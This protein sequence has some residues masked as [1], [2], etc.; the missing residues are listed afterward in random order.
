ML[1]RIV[2]IHGPQVASR[3]RKA[4]SHSISMVSNILRLALGNTARTDR[5]S[6][7]SERKQVIASHRV[8]GQTAIHHGGSAGSNVSHTLLDRTSNWL[9]SCAMKVI[10]TWQPVCFSRRKVEKARTL[11]VRCFNP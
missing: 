7:I 9:R 5:L 6:G 8:K 10:P 2:K 1:T 4:A 3:R 11:P